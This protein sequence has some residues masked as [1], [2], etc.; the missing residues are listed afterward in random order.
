MKKILSTILIL[1]SIET[2][3][4][5]SMDT[6]YVRNLTLRWEEWAWLKGKWSPADSV[7]K[8]TFR[9]IRSAVLDANPSSFTTNITI[10][11]IPGKTAMIFYTIFNNSSKAETAPMSNN[12]SQNIKNYA[13]MTAFC[14]LFDAVPVA[15]YQN[16]RKNGKEDLLDNN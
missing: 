8:K 7:E 13:P 4:Q 9:K 6:I 11:S 2:F 14:N 3:S 5:G 1:V 10:D 12:I 16:T 15:I